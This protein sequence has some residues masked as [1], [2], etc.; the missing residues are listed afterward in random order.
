MGGD[1]RF[2]RQHTDRQYF[3]PHH[4]CGWWLK[5]IFVL[6]SCITISI[7]TTRVGGD[8]YDNGKEPKSYKF[9]ST[10]P[11]WVVTVPTVAELLWLIISIHTTRVGG[12]F[13]HFSC[14]L[15]FNQFQST[16]PVWVVTSTNNVGETNKI[17]FNPH[18]PCGWWLVF[19]LGVHCT[20]LISIHTTRVGGDSVCSGC[21]LHHS[22]FNPHHPC[23]WWLT[24]NSLSN[25]FFPISIHTTRVGG[26]WK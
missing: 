5:Y 12:D 24:D 10:P 7:H 16:P 13:F 17:Y 4:P 15:F 20:I 8:E 9:Q 11:V 6:I 1:S 26:D 18:H 14:F 19:V 21:S 25:I 23:G 2:F 22:H 3:N